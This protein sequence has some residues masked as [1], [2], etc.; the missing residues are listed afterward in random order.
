MEP[1]RLTRRSDAGASFDDLARELA[2]LREENARLRGLLGL[3][4]RAAGG[5]QSAWAPTLL[6]DPSPNAAIAAT[7]PVADK[8]A[9]LR[10]LFGAR[11]DVYAARWESASTG[12]VGWS[13]ATR[14]GWS[15][16]DRRRTT[17]R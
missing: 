3:D 11:S 13:P 16:A 10:S 7:A 12:K 17:C 8:V 2:E 5:H 1:S 9:L 4:T 15:N 6:N 14:G